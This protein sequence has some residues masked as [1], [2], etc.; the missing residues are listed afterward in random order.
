MSCDLTTISW[1]YA[2]MEV[3]FAFAGAFGLAAFVWAFSKL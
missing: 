1:A 2:F 3:G